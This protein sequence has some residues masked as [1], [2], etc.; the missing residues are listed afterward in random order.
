MAADDALSLHPLNGRDFT[1]GSPLSLYRLG[2]LPAALELARAGYRVLLT[3]RDAAKGQGVLEEIRRATGNDALEL[4]VGDLSNMNEVRRIAAEQ[5]EGE[6]RARKR[7]EV[8]RRAPARVG[9]G[10]RTRA[11]Q[12]EVFGGE[13]ADQRGGGSV[14]GVYRGF[15][16]TALCTKHSVVGVGTRKRLAAGLRRAEAENR[17]GTLRL[18]TRTAT[19]PSH[20][21]FG[22]QVT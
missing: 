2:G 18:P 14:V 5:G 4:F 11:L 13:D 16:H 22:S 3:A 9:D 12:G 10:G 7:A 19:D 21:V 8:E 17:W 15:A 1:L 20:K 6:Q